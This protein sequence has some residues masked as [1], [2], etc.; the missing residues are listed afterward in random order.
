MATAFDY[1]IIAALVAVAVIGGVSR[2][3][4]HPSPEVA[5]SK[6]SEP[7]FSTFRLEEGQTADI[8][9]DDPASPRLTYSAAD[10]PVFICPAGKKVDLFDPRTGHCV[11]N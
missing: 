6:E 11:P 1:G 2:L 4:E 7:I 9:F 8:G 3:N 5:K 10:G